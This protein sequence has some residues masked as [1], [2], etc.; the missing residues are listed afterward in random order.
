MA[1]LG[2]SFTEASQLTE[3]SFKEHTQKKQDADQELEDMEQEDQNEKI[4]LENEKLEVDCPTLLKQHEK[5]K[6]D[7][8]KAKQLKVKLN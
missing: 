3:E 2:I 8:L 4:K 6:A 7:R 5:R 1:L